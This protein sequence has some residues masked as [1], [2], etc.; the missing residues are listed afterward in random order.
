MA[1]EQAGS[2][3]DAIRSWADALG[4]LNP[5]DEAAEQS[6]DAQPRPKVPQAVCDNCPICQGAATVDSINPLVLNELTEIARSLI[7][8]VGAALSQAAETRIAVGRSRAEGEAEGDVG[9]AAPQ[10]GGDA[11][12]DGH[13]GA[14]GEPGP[15]AEPGVVEE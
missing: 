12:A 5:P 1:Q 11:V 4:L 13:A 10:A 15:A 9:S 7:A 6:D 14:A 8:G 2:Y 3:W